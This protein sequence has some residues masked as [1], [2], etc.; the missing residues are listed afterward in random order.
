[1]TLPLEILVY[2]SGAVGSS[3]G[4]WIA[5]RYPQITLLARD[6]HYQ[7]IK[8]KSLI[9]RNLRKKR[10][11][12]VKINIVND[13][14]KKSDANV[15]ILSLKNYDLELAAKDI[16]TKLGKDVI[17]VALQNG[18]KNQEILSKY[19][20]KVIYG[21]VCYNAWVEKPGVVNYYDKRTIYLGT[22]ENSLKNS[23]EEIYSIFNLGT[24]TE[25]T[26]NLQSATYSKIVLNLTNSL[27]T[28]VGLD[29][30]TKSAFNDIVEITYKIL[31]EGIEV[32]KNYGIEEHKLSNLP[33]WKIIA[34]GQKLPKF[35]SSSIAYRNSKKS[36]INSMAQD[37]IIKKKNQSELESLNGHIIQIADARNIP[38]PYNKAIY[39]ICMDRF[40]QIPFESMSAKEI[41]EEIKKYLT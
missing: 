41:N 7:E 1:M 24:R 30:K 11:E 39:Q 19:F 18:V 26:K 9:L 29:I 36:V 10:E 21:I 14:I 40:S 15:V 4:G 28:L 13:I 16:V 22:D 8:K 5:K 37:I 3:L 6:K 32:L 12:N 2:G 23:I 20:S 27:F 33:S 17:I 34:L 35:I 38:I 31:S 25:L